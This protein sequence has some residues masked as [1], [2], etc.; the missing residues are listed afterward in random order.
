[1]KKR[2]IGISNLSILNLLI[3]KE[4]NNLLILYRFHVV[5]GRN[6]ETNGSSIRQL[7]K[8]V[9]LELQSVQQWLVCVLFASS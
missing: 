3:Y 7:Q 5:Y 6:T 1:M 4:T 9:S 2:N 8:W